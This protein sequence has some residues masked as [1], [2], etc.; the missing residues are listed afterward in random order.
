MKIPTTVELKGSGPD[1]SVGSEEHYIKRAKGR[2]NPPATSTAVAITKSG[3]TTNSG[4]ITA[5]LSPL[6]G[7]T[8]VLSEYMEEF[9]EG[10]KKGKNQGNHRNIISQSNSI[11]SNMSRISINSKGFNKGEDAKVIKERKLTLKPNDYGTLEEEEESEE[12]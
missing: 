4:S 5:F 7:A 12:E 1:F 9:I 10:G 2:K 6:M 8:E 11:S 3:G